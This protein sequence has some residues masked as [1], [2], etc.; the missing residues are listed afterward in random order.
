M[1]EDTLESVRF[2]GAEDL[3][4]KEQPFSSLTSKSLENREKIESFG[5]YHH[6]H[7]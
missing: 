7:H 1:V 6:R 2:T 5:D 3:E 4:S